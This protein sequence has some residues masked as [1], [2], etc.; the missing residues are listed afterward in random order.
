MFYNIAQ[1]RTPSF[2]IGLVKIKSDLLL[3]QLRLALGDELVVAVISVDAYPAYPFLAFSDLTCH[4][5]D[6]GICVFWLHCAT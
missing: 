1:L 4:L 3:D 5:E 2:P 6:T